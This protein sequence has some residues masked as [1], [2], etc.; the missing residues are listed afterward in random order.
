MQEI[1]PECGAAWSAQ[2]NCVERF[3]RFMGLEMTDPQ[4]GAVHHLTV[5]AYMLQHP[6]QLSLRGWEEE[7]NLLR[8]FLL[9]GVTPQQVRARGRQYDSGVRTWSL[10]KG[11]RLELPTGFRWTST[12]MSVDESSPEQ[13]SQDIQ[14][15]ARHVLDQALAI[16]TE[17]E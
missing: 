15:W 3:G 5:P 9:E 8:Q 17:N 14:R 12:I 1:C 7:R 4:Y 13:Y 2:D 6:S 10:R 11:P 16:R